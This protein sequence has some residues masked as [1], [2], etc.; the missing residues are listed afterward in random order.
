MKTMPLLPTCREM[1]EQVT[2]YLEHALPLRRRLAARLHLALCSACTHY[3]DQMRRTAALLRSRRPPPP[4]GAV[5][6]E[7][8]QRLG[9]PPS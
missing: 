1:T 7:I 5:E 6:D 3:F 4:A 9:K 8:L 2:D